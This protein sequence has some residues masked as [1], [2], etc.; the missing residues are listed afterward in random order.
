MT[1]STSLS[2]IRA[3]AVPVNDL[4]GRWLLDAVTLQTGAEAGY[5]NPFAWYMAG[6]GG[7]LGDVDADV[8][9]SAFGYF[10]PG[11]VRAMWEAGVAIEGARACADRY[12]D[13][14]ADWGRA[15]LDGAAGLDRIA[16]LGQRWIAAVSPCGLTL[17]A[18][19]RAQPLPGDAAG[20][21]A[22]TLHVLREL[23][24]SVHICAT[25]AAGLSP[26]DAVLTDPHAGSDRAK[27]FG[28]P[29]PHH[30]VVH[31]TDRR[32]SADDATD[33]ILAD[34]IDAA[35]TADE[36]AELTD[37]VLALRQHVNKA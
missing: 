4:G 5:A 1:A 16:E 13:A 32:R 31:L 8:V 30:D 25:T 34:Q 22:L 21:A 37:L 23:R 18:G 15:H 35:L 20:R 6:R 26:L 17:F 10:A 7:V 3:L 24:G 27:M 11:S 19:W 28:W 33:A 9:T 14:C 2:T 29:E 12:T 36:Q